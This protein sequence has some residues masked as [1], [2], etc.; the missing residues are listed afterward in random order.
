MINTINKKIDSQWHMIGRKNFIHHRLYLDTIQGLW[1]YQIFQ[2]TLS[3]QVIGSSPV[4]AFAM[5]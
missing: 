3:S 1:A 4:V 5:P 2:P